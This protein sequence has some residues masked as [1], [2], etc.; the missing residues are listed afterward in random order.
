MK[1]AFLFGTSALV[2]AGL[3]ASSA[4]AA[5][6]IEIKVGGFMNQWFG[7]SDNKDVD[8]F[9]S[10]DQWSNSEII[11][12]GKTTLDNGLTVG[13]NV[14]LEA[15]TTDDQIDESYAFVQGSFG[16]F[17]IGS[18]KDAGSL[19]QVAA[20]NVGLSI[21]DGYVDQYIV[22]T[23]GQS[24]D[25]FG[26]ALGS[27]YITDKSQKI[28]YFTPRFSGFQLGVS[29]SPDLDETGDRNSLVSETAAYT[30]GFSV[31]LNYTNSFSGVDVAGA[32]G[33][34]YAGAPDGAKDVVEKGDVDDFTAYTAGLNLGMGGFTVGGSYA[35]INDGAIAGTFSTEGQAYDVGLSYET[36]AIGASLTY[37]HGESD[38]DRTVS[39]DDENDS[40]VGSLRYNLGQGVAVIGSVGYTDFQ[41]ELPGGSDDNAGYYVTSGLALR[42]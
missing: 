14:Q 18:S 42:F 25:L 21:N 40:Y 27:T 30:D 20:P 39:R 37:F 1:K 19:M 24:L 29:Y 16:R 11:F 5:E 13:L 32:L 28:S 12:S 8:N 6:P 15:N 33:Y 41:G 23:T 4:Q 3:F 31:G 9:Q 26:S 22:N 7:Y 38:A 35:N 2:A 10:F 36:G 17:N 34:Y